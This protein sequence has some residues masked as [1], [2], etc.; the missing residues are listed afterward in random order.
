[1]FRRRLAL[2]SFL[3]LSFAAWALPACD[4][5]NDSSNDEADDE[6]NSDADSQ[7]GDDTQEGDSTTEEGEESNGDHS[8]QE[9]TSG[10]TDDG[11]GD[12]TE[13]SDGDDDDDDDSSEGDESDS[14]N[15]TSEE[16]TSDESGDDSSDDD[17]T[18][19]TN[20]N[21]SD[22][23]AACEVFAGAEVEELVA[24]SEAD[25]AAQVVVKPDS[26]KAY[27]VKI[28]E[29]KAGYITY[30]FGEWDTTQAFYVSMDATYTVTVDGGDTQ[31]ERT[32]VASCPDDPIT[33]QLIKFEH[34][35]P[36]TI[37]FSETGP[38]EVWLMVYKAAT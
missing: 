22:D 14:E 2:M 19:T 31:M 5:G 3:S 4:G 38:R 36:A 37:M 33:E 13:A 18:T 20:P 6:S 1:M 34:W 7:E 28:E 29:G 15:S 17:T 11:D 9:S 23:T 26:T 16:T 8:S 21:G 30:E 27:R 35:T 32:P 24:A 10:E 12:E 25:E